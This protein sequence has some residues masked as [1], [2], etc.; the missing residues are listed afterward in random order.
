MGDPKRTRK[1][2]SK[3]RHPWQE[4][5]IK[6]EAM[7]KKKY[8][9]KNKTEVWKMNSELRRVRAQARKLITGLTE[10]AIKEQKALL[11]SLNALGLL[12]KN[13]K[14]EDV[15]SLTLE[16]FMERRLQTIVYK[17]GLAKTIKHARQLI[18]HKKILCG[19]KVITSPSYLV[20]VKEEGDIRVKE[21]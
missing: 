13:A 14:I 2:Y 18:T 19:G 3:P 5:R 9:Y 6:R 8:G 7:L 10:Q 15:L 20:K 11:Q 12:D 4:E 21:T 1:K 17:K 16:D